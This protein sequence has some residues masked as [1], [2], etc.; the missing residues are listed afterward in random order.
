MREGENK[1]RFR[2]LSPVFAV[3]LIGLFLVVSA[4]WPK[5]KAA[6][7]DDGKLRIVCTFL[8]VYVFAL[9]VV[10]DDPQVDVQLM[11]DR[12]V[13]CPHSYSLTG[14]DLKLISRADLLLANGLGA[15]PF[16]HQ[17]LRGR[18][19]LKVLTLSDQCDLI[20]EPGAIAAVRAAEAQ[21]QQAHQGEGCDH[22]GCEHAAHDH[23]ACEHAD[24][25]HAD[26]D[27]EG[28]EHA[29]DDHDH[30]E[31]QGHHDHADEGQTHSHD[32]DVNPHTWVSPR[33]AARQVRTLAVKLGRED[34]DRAEA[35][36]ANAEAYA[37]RLE[38]LAA[39]ME[40]A[41]LTFKNRNIVTG[42]AS[43][44][45]LARDLDL[46][47]VAT[48]RVIPG[49]TGSATEMARVIDAVRAHNA[50]AIFWEPPFGDKLAEAVARETGRPVYPLNPFNTDA[51]LPDPRTPEDKRRMYEDVM[52]K[53][54]STLQ[55]ALAD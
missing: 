10:G 43:F 44:D 37:Q 52:E 46:N 36:K 49:E 42:H 4:L 11:V 54:L 28:H 16:L 53:N 26:C 1:T 38:A 19:K 12:D 5:S 40:A 27:H 55:R 51:G 32:A 21:F 2:L 48:L 35:Y 20:G 47:I 41:A 33:Q 34:P 45:Y 17:L 8:P 25:E 30:A 22:Q 50:A 24:C 29:H 13:G 3:T 15:E 39:R 7:N 6:A 9:N 23:D 14:R 18:P 31:C